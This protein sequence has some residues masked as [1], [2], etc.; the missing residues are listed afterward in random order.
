MD[1]KSI[2]IKYLIV[3][4][5]SILVL[6]YL[7]KLNDKVIKL[8]KVAY[9]F[10]NSKVADTNESTDEVIQEILDMDD[11][12]IFNF[13]HHENDDFP[14]DLS[15]DFEND[16]PYENMSAIDEFFPATCEYHKDQEEVHQEEV[17]QEEVRQEEVHQE[18]VHQEEVHQEEVHQEE[19]HQEEVHQEESQMVPVK[20]TK[21]PRKIAKKFIVSL[22]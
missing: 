10:E 18:E 17:H 22:E 12:D 4:I 2:N 21:K 16:S 8:E 14:V 13:T 15:I 9:K 3:F 6:Y 7:F 1:F 19:V 5:S 20:K 11:D